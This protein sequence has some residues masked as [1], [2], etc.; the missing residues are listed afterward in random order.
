MNNILQELNDKFSHDRLERS[1]K[2]WIDV[3]NG[4]IPD[5]RFPFTLEFP[6]FNVYNVS[7]P[8]EQRL[9]IFTKAYSF[10]SQFDDDTVPVVFPG[11]DHATIPSM[12]G[13]KPVQAGMETTSEKMIF[14][15]ADIDK[16]PEP[17]VLPG[18]PAEY[19]VEA[20]RYMKEASEDKILISVCDMQGPFDACAQIWGYDDMF[21]C[22]YQ[23]P[24]YYDKIITK[25]TDA[26]ILLW[27]KQ[28]ET[29]GAAFQGTHLF[30]WGFV[31]PENGVTVS[32]DSL[33]MISV[34]F[35]EKYYRPYLRKIYDALGPITIHSCGDFSHLVPSLCQTE[36]IKAINTSQMTIGQMTEAGFDVSK[37]LLVF[38]SFD[39]LEREIG[40]ARREGI[41]PRLC[42]TDVWPKNDEGQI[43]DVGT[44]TNRHFAQIQDKVNRIHELLRA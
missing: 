9:N 27:Q 30:G 18:S 12:F 16:L 24:E 23:D 40:I 25:L 26:F 8:P 15:V 38:V 17:L 11:L 3:E 2:R 31:L 43:A 42:I 10:L 29:L 5:D 33:V 22:A 34:D 39:D 6:Y 13:A 14:D 7:H 1:K 19:W 4:K 32:V 36:E 41:I 21:I 20:E 37:G 35:Y 28:K 44:W